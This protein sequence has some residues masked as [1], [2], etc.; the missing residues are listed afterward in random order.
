MQRL[1]KLQVRTAL[2]ERP[3]EMIDM[4]S[5][6]RVYL[7]LAEAAAQPAEAAAEKEVA[8]NI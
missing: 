1:A 6:G 4:R 5:E 8:E 3:L 7:R 2:T